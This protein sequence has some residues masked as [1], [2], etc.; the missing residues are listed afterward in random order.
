MTTAKERIINELQRTDDPN[1][2]A[3]FLLMM[4][5]LEEI[6]DKIDTVISDEKALRDIVLNGHEPVHH[7]HHDWIA[8]RI[9]HNGRCEW[10]NKEVIKQAEVTAAKKSIMDKIVEN[11]INQL[12]TI[13]ITG[14]AVAAGFTFIK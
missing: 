1:L 6:G 12:S 10:A 4:A 8:N 5:V 7:V 14:L 2:K 11:I 3:V 13:I 9:S